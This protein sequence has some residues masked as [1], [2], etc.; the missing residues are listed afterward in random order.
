MCRLLL[1]GNP[2]SGKTTLYNRMT[3]SRERVG[4]WHGVTV[5]ARTAK[6]KGG[7]ELVDLPGLYSLSAYSPE[8]K[9]AVDELKKG[10]DVIVNVVEAVNL[11]RAL[12]LTRELALRGKR[13]IVVINMYKELTR[14]GGSI[15]IKRLSSHLGCPVILG[16]EADTLL[17]KS[18]K[19]ARKCRSFGELPNGTFTPPRQ[20]GSMGASALSNGFFGIVCFAFVMCAVFYLAF[21]KYGLGVI[22]GAFFEKVIN[23]AMGF[24]GERL[25]VAG[26][27]GRFIADGL[28]GGIAGVIGFLPQ[29]AVMQL[30]LILIEESGYLS[31]VAVIFDGVL[32][33]A[34]L[35]GK[36]VFPLLVGFGCS[37]TAILSSRATENFSVKKRTVLALHF[38]PCM[39]RMPAF[40]FLATSF[41][42]GREFLTVICLYLLGIALAIGSAY[43][44]A[45]VNGVK[46][47]PL[48][49]ELPQ[50]K[51]PK[52]IPTLKQLNYYLK[53][54]IIKIGTVLVA[55]SAVLWALRSFSPSFELLTEER[56]SESILARLGSMLSFLF[57]PIGLDGWQMPV[58]M[59]SGLIAKEGIVSA[60]VL[61]YPNGV[62]GEISLQSALAVLVF[63]AYYTPCVMAVAS[64]KREVGGRLSA[65]YAAFSFLMALLLSYV[66]YGL[67]VCLATFG[68]RNIS[69]GRVMLAAAC[70]AIS[71][72]IVFIIIKLKG[73]INDKICCHG[74]GEN[75]KACCGCGRT[76]FSREKASP[77]KGR[78]A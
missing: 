55:V 1:V 56:I 39:A 53:T 66:V 78:K 71:A 25:Q 57:K 4:N 29:L 77:Q 31:R 9:I 49:M 72:L 63:V 3:G 13:I 46:P 69:V 50:I 19:S 37:A 65:F 17:E 61:A 11:P 36:A 22:C 43:F 54:F 45:R 41:F 27:F 20:G 40:I 5:D 18:L 16:E 62:V 59:L 30:C 75:C 10:D 6:T 23:F 8:E 48:I 76:V 58:A 44:S 60:L 51:I 42:K 70:C 74:K 12:L 15:D 21:G 38:L 52:L 32:K 24:V 64:A 28:L 73:R 33:R 2:N 67:A 7:L 26:A 47:A 35:S 14:R 34:G 68:S